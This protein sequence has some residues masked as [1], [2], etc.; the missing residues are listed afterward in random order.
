MIGQYIRKSIFWSLDMAKGSPV[1]KAYHTVD[2]VIADP[3][4]PDS[5]QMRATALREILKHACSTTEF[6][7]N[8]Q[9]IDDISQFPLINKSIIKENLDSF[10][11][12]AFS[13][14]D[15]YPAITSGST[16]TPFKT[17]QTKEKKL[18]TSA[19]TIYFAGLAGFE[20]G[21]ELH[22]FKIWSD[23]NKKNAVLS[24]MQNIYQIDVIKLSDAVLEKAVNDLTR[25]NAPKGIL[26]YSSALEQLC[27]F[28]DR[29]KSAPLK[30]NVRSIISMSES[31]N[32]YTR[33]ALYR[34]FAVTACSR[35]SNIEN[36]I[37]A[38]QTPT[39][40]GKY[41]I[42]T[43][44]F[45]VEIFDLHKNVVAKPGEL[46]RIVVTDLCNYATPLIRY[47]TGDIGSMP[48][49]D[50][51]TID[52]EYLA[53]V[54]GRKLDLLYD[55]KGDLI[56]SFIMYKNMWQY[57]EIT[58]YQLIQEDEKR[59]VFKVNAPENFQHEAKLMKEFKQYLGEEADF[60]IE[61]VKEIPLLSSGK[62]KKMVN[63]FKK[64]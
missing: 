21:H 33:D 55:T 45:Y 63:N 14:E 38:Q 5:S 8:I 24:W 47:D 54:E 32:Q 23:Y 29:R 62:R 26:G 22:Y 3:T 17:F 12:S 39:S 19:D 48:L 36:G 7:K 13:K 40:A 16:G 1:K 42:N 43:A 52:R 57:P 2:K 50:D 60:T 25:N 51:N 49:K 31:L 10:L 56:S 18:R 11:S 44:S 9:A 20:V 6:Y 41:K 59:Y 61:Y 34:Y 35:Y 53:H 58:Q 30:A 28:L 15:L 4:S 64:S 46:G 37:L 27:M